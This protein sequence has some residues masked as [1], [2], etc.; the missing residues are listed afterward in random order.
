MSP[1]L[2]LA[3]TLL[4]IGSA[5]A[6]GPDLKL[7]PSDEWREI[8][9]PEPPPGTIDGRFFVWAGNPNVRLRVGAVKALR[10]SYD[11]AFVM[12]VSEEMGKRTRAGGPEVRV[13][14]GITFKLDGASVAKLRTVDERDHTLLFYLPGD[15]GDVVVALMGLD[16]AWDK[17]AEDEVARTVNAVRHLRRPNMTLDESVGTAT[18]VVILVTLFTIALG[19]ILV[20]VLRR[21]RQ[22]DRS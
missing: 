11:N 19:G 22:A 14:E 12:G 20:A 6:G 5:A 21:R 18:N 16:G 9:D 8:A 13:T 17:K 2:I 4:A 3:G 1:G 10:Q 7:P 15:E